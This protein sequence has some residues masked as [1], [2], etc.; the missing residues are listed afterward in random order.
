MTAP[1]WTT[2]DDDTLR[3]LHA[4]GKSCHAIAT[5]MTRSK[6]TISRHSKRLGL[7]WDRAQVAAAT[8]AKQTDAKGRR[9]TL[10]LS[11]LE[12]AERLRE[13]LWQPCIAFN[14]GGK[15]NTYEEHHLDKPTFADQLK[16]MQATGVAV[17]RSLRLADH[18]SAGSE[19]VKNILGSL[20]EQ[21]GL[22]DRADAQ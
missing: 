12:D 11:L 1:A 8:A 22:T 3:A 16:I 9:A 13:Q 20:A 6:A 21:L 10:Q 5:E 18:D 17:D 15:D 2:A 7:L 4:A 14:F 19:V